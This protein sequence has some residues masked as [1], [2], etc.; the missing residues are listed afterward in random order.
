MF[1]ISIRSGALIIKDEY[2][3][4]NYWKRKKVYVCVRIDKKKKEIDKT[5]ERKKKERG[6]SYRERERMRARKTC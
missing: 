3:T 6:E 5:K 2:N 1:N 4:T